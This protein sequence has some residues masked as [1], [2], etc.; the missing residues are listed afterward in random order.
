MLE[1][2]RSV[3]PAVAEIVVRASPDLSALIVS[4]PAFDCWILT[5]HSGIQV[6]VRTLPRGEHATLSAG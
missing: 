1:P 4:S 3:L 6:G 2:M 5:F